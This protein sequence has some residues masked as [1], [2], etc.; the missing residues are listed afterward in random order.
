MG[1]SRDV[2]R[3]GPAPAQV[4]GWGEGIRGLWLGVGGWIPPQG[5]AEEGDSSSEPE[6]VFG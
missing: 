3:P 5:A 6:S 2:T 4:R 1:R